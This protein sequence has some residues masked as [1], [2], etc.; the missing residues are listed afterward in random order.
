MVAIQ[1]EETKKGGTSIKVKQSFSPP[2]PA[3]GISSRGD[4]M[5]SSLCPSALDLSWLWFFHCF[6]YDVSFFHSLRYL[7]V[8]SSNI[9]GF[10]NAVFVQGCDAYG[11]HD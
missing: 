3:L 8:E 4:H 10:V 6:R 7:Q 2:V 1:L 5:G 11:L 9:D